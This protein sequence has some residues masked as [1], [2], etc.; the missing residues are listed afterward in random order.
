MRQSTG[1]ILGV[2]A[3]YH[4]SAACLIG[5]GGDI[6]AAS[7]E[8]RWSRKRHDAGWP[9]MAIRD[10]L[11]QAD[12]ALEKITAVAF[13]EK[14]LLKLSRIMEELVAQPKGGF[15]RF[16]ATMPLWF[17]EKGQLAERIC[18]TLQALDR[19]V[20]WDE[21]LYFV[22]HHV[23]HA[24]S[25]FYPSPFARAAVLTVDGVGE[26]TTTAGFLG[27]GT[28]LEPLWEVRYPQ[29]L[30]M[31]YSAFTYYCGFRVNSGEYKLM[32]LAPYGRPTYVDIVKEQVIE[33]YE[34]GSY[35]L[36]LSLFDH[37]SGET[38]I[39]DEHFARLFGEPRRTEKEKPRQFHADIAASVQKVL[40][41]ALVGLARRLRRET[42]EDALCL[43][44]GVA[45]NCVAN[46]VLLQE[47][48]FT[49]IWIQPAAGDAGG[50]L[51]AAMHL[52]Y[53]QGGERKNRG[54]CSNDAMQGA[55]LGPS[56][57][58]VEVR[59]VLDGK[60]ARYHQMTWNELLEVAVN[61]LC[62]GRFIGWF[63][64][65]MEYG[66]RALGARSILADPRSPSVQKHL[67][68]R[69]KKRESFRP[70]APIVL[71][72]EQAK[73]FELGVDSP[74]MLFVDTLKKEWRG[75]PPP[76]RPLEALHS[77]PPVDCAV[78]AV[79]H[80]DWS[81]RIQTVGEDSRA[82]HSLLQRFFVRTACPM[83]LNTSFNVRGEPIVCTPGD[84]YD[85]F[86]NAGLDLL[87]IEDCVLYNDEQD[88]INTQAARRLFP[89]D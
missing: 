19:T 17:D 73:W 74:Y 2:S 36:N 18:E 8:E 82:L 69:T 22:E 53:S 3:F 68:L 51:G 79:I 41:E 9:H 33:L 39:N 50:A 84:A 16:L 48:G 46:T 30:G 81:A 38:I 28:A 61:A 49:K 87:I 26:K 20:R 12:V 63:Q 71:A 80:L 43:A 14:P 76:A 4:D 55:R 75:N 11:R 89:P 77:L 7:Q 31:F 56:Y 13:Y 35:A 37:F 15:P 58:G 78:P 42:Q 52:Y 25:C 5:P 23:S 44:G 72:E 67:N 21:R 60:H 34:N 64:G 27:Q 86:L 70:F 59:Q 65:R 10:C 24:A 40:E 85:A 47:A 45:L 88:S 1:Y 66:P 62:A 6:V 57:T 54:I 32:G 83:L 29:S